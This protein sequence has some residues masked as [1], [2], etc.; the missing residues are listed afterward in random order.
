MGYA[1]PLEEVHDL[2]RGDGRAMRDLAKF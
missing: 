2:D 1:L